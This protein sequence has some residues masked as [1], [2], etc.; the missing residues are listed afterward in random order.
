MSLAQARRLAL[1]LVAL[2]MPAAT[3]LAQ[4]PPAGRPGA[5]PA[6][7]PAAP[8][9]AEAPGSPWQVS[10]A[11]ATDPAAT[12]RDCQIA[13][14]VALRQSNERLAR[15]IIRRQPESRSLTMV[16]QLPHGAWLPTGV[17]WQVD[18]G[19]AQRLAFQTSDAE[20]LYAGIAITDDLLAGLRRGTTL[21]LGVVAAAQRQLIN[22][23]VPL[24]RLTESFTE[25]T[26]QERHR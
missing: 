23:P 15:V 14:T 18:E 2:A 1:T 3:A 16:F 26:A 21:R 17:Q 13:A 4:T 10:C 8:A 5:R 12:G 24:A 19:E 25:F 11:P 22:I 20:G 9:A 6:T 7:P